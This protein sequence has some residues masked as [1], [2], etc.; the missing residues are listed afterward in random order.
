MQ[1]LFIGVFAILL[2]VLAGALW[3]HRQ[4]ALHDGQRRAENLALILGDH[5]ARTVGAVDAALCQLALYSNSVGGPKAPADAWAPVIEAA[6]SGLSGIATLSVLDAAGTV[7]HSTLPQLVGASRADMCVFDLLSRDPTATLLID[8]PFRGQ[9]SGQWVIPLA[10]RLQAPDGTF[11]GIVTAALEPRRMRGFYRTIDI[12]RDGIIWVAHLTGPIVLREPPP[13]GS[14][15]SCSRSPLLAEQAAQSFGF[16]RKPL[17]PG[18]PVYLSAFRRIDGPPLVV[19][20]SF[21]EHEVLAEWW[22]DALI[23]CIVA[24]RSRSC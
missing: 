11:A 24:A 21:A 3:L 15:G 10:R 8:V 1:A 20:V 4:D 23:A 17:T 14:G 13:P 6:K 5:L 7:V 22:G 18:G 19:T 2:A 9:L 16:L 12:G